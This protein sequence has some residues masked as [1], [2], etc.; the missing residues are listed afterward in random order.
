MEYQALAFRDEQEAQL[1]ADVGCKHG[2]MKKKKL[3]DV[4]TL[5]I[6]V[7]KSGVTSD[8]GQTYAL[9]VIP[10]EAVAGFDV[11][12]A[13]DVDLDKFKVATLVCFSL[14]QSHSLVF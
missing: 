10:T 2:D 4:T 5:N 14:L 7:L 3:G 12:I 8:G 1:G 11:R 13:P 6:T 9:N